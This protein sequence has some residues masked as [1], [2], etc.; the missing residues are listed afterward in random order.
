MTLD[1]VAV[2]IVFYFLFTWASPQNTDLCHYLEWV[3]FHSLALSLSEAGC[4]SEKYMPAG[5]P[6]STVL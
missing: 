5:L 1:G 6:N 4:I 3:N 2:H